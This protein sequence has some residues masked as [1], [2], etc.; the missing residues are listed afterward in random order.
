MTHLG[1]KAIATNRL[2]L[3]RFEPA[4]AVD[5]FQTWASDDQV[6]CYMSWPPHPAIETSQQ[7]IA[8][9]VE[10]YQN[11]AFYNWAIVIKATGQLIGSIGLI[12]VDN[13]NQR[14]EAG[15]CIGRAFWRQGYTSEALAGVLT[16]LF[17]EVGFNRIEARH[18][19]RNPNSGGV[20][21]KCGMVYEGTLR[22][23]GI[24]RQGN[25]Y[26]S[27]IYASLRSEFNG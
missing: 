27:K 9:W 23:Y 6:S 26:D 4:D 1:T 3:R 8:D 22:Q 20:M 12:G 21:L 14:A 15:Y 7:V 25:P 2:I 19:V 16:F 17:C 10:C 18:D 5:M 13:Q 24:D 11:V